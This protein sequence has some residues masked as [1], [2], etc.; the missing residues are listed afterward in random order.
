MPTT[1]L[2][3]RPEEALR[4]RDQI[5]Q[6]PPP[7]LT[8]PTTVNAAGWELLQRQA[9][10]LAAS[11]M[12]PDRY[13]GNIPNCIIAAELAFRMKISP[14]AVM[15][16]LYVVHG[17]PGWLTPFL[18]ASFNSCGR[19]TSMRFAW[20]DDDTEC[21][22]WAIERAT[23]ERI[24]GPKVS[25]EMAKAEGWYNRKD[26]K[27]RTMPE[28]MLTY[29]AAAFLVRTS[30]PELTLGL[31][32][33]EEIIDSGISIEPP[34][35]HRSSSLT[36][37]H[38]VLADKA[39][40]EERDEGPQAPDVADMLRRIKASEEQ[41]LQKVRDIIDLIDDKHPDKPVLIEAL[42]MRERILQEPDPEPNPIPEESEEEEQQP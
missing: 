6:Q 34:P 1:D 21:R 35:M 16:N 11:D 8:E 20:N 7:Q 12:V 4:E 2:L 36:H 17:K 14:F 31:Q 30:A 25:I 23:R 9:K 37:I 24:E 41:D 19:Y 3:I 5:I 26:S 40:R 33:K 10:A 22:A 38:Q 42:Q 15:Q 18:I 29:R 27:W 39:D 13:Q 32:T 28:L